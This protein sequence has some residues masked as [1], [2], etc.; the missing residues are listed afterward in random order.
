MTEDQQEPK[1]TQLTKPKGRDKDG[2]PYE[3]VEIPLPSD[4][5]VMG[6]LKKVAHTEAEKTSD[7]A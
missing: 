4:A 1:P 6:L 2:N 5:D 3:P 7:A